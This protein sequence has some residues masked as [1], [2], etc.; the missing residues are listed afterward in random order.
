[1]P[2]PDGTDSEKGLDVDDPDPPDLHV[3][4]LNL[5][6]VPD[7]DVVAPASSEHQ[8]VGHESM[9][10]FDQVENTLT[11]SDAALPDKEEPDAV[12]VG[13]GAMEAHRGRQSRFQVWIQALEE[14][15]GAHGSPEHRNL[16]RLGG[17]KKE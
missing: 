3:M 2:L 6:A 5:V 4:P 16:V 13:Q 1:M 12:H 9:A 10:P 8:I 14:D 15:S 17:L 7:D 11:L